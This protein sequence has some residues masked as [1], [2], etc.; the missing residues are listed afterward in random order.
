MDT[1]SARIAEAAAGN[2][3]AQDELGRVLTIR[4][5][6]P[7][8]RLRMFKAL[9]PE[10]AQ[11]TTYLGMAMLAASVTAIDDIPVPMPGNELQLEALVQKLG[12]AGFAAIARALDGMGEVDA[13]N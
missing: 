10:L 1:P 7:V 12:D 6:G 8:D 13:G 11:N 3:T 2:A 5:P 9:G 4:R